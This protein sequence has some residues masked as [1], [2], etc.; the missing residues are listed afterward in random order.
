MGAVFAGTRHRWGRCHSGHT[1]C[2]DSDRLRSEVVSS[3]GRRLGQ[4][5]SELRARPSPTSASILPASGGCA[6][7]LRG[8]ELHRVENSPLS[9]SPLRTPSE[10]LRGNCRS[11]SCRCDSRPWRTPVPHCPLPWMR[12]PLPP[13]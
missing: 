13:L 11:A 2:A 1:S 10:L 9:S 12:G 7:S 3:G 8:S 4:V 5:L 6:A